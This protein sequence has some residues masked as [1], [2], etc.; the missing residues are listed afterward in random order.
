MKAAVPLKNFFSPNFSQKKK[1]PNF[2]WS[3]FVVKLARLCIIL[4]MPDFLCFF[5]WIFSVFSPLTP[6]IYQNIWRNERSTSRDQRFYSENEENPGLVWAQFVQILARFR[7]SLVRLWPSLDTVWS[8]SGLVLVRLGQIRSS[9]S[10][11]PFTLMVWL[12]LH[13]KYWILRKFFLPCK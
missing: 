1:S 4:Q 7:S 10:P 3:A 9:S 11:I 2:L 6:D 8:D 12:R 13:C 5:A